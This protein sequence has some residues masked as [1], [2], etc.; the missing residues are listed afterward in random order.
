VFN[1]CD[2]EDSRANASHDK[3]SNLHPD[4][5]EQPKPWSRT[6]KLTLAYDILTG[7]L[8]V[9]ALGTAIAIGWQAMKTAQATEAMRQST[10]IQRAELV[11][12]V[13]IEEWS[14]AEDIWLTDDAKDKPLIH[15]VTFAFYIANPTNY[16]MNLRRA[17]WHIG[18]RSGWIDINET[19]FPPRGRH[20]TIID[21]E[22][23]EEEFE[24]YREGKLHDFHITGSVTFI[25]VS[26]VEQT[27]CFRVALNC[28]FEKG[29]VGVK[30]Y[31]TAGWQANLSNKKVWSK[32]ES[33]TENPN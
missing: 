33:E 5:Q 8:V 19:T 21:H 7:F 28:A 13:D 20:S 1:D 12:W 2:D 25:D 16:P 26:K 29:V 17:D 11:Q 15:S 10:A 18:R 6:D 24:I 4:G 14:G 23:T 3:A 9:I 27:Q 32:N 22:L 30:H 31:E